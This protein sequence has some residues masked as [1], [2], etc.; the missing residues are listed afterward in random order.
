MQG[1]V[2]LK[3]GKTRYE[4]IENWD[5]PLVVFVH[6]L[7][8]P[9]WAWDRQFDFFSKEF[10]VLR[11]DMYGKGASQS[12]Y[13]RYDREL[14]VNQ[15]EELLDKFPNKSVY[16]VGHSLGAAI[17]TCFAGSGHKKVKKMVLINPFFALPIKYAVLLNGV[18]IPIL[19]NF[20]SDKIVMKIIEKRAHSFFHTTGD[21]AGHY[22]NLF[23]KDIEVLKKTLYTLFLGD[24]LKSYSK[25]YSKL[26]GTDT[27]LCIIYGSRDSEVKFSQVEKISNNIN[28]AKVFVMEGSGHAPT[29]EETGRFNKT[30]MDFLKS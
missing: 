2:Q 25:T 7:S 20:L 1:T 13:S 23:F 19:G 9:M 29:I 14:Y 17:C 27:E 30:L 8:I 24:A 21:E 10:S 16:L 15:L 28:G 4:Y 5:K 26:S 18:K 3:S 6:G 12:D 22:E 11:Y